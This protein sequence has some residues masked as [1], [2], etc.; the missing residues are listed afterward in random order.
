MV[1]RKAT[2]AFDG[3]YVMAGMIGHGDMFVLRDPA[4]IRPVFY[5]K[6]DEIGGDY[7]RT[8]ATANRSQ[9]TNRCRPGG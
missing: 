1:L 7:L 9:C 4:G 3:G 6:D 2:K 8:P 5:Y